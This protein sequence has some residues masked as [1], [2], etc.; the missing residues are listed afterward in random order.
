MTYCWT[1]AK[2]RLHI[3]ERPWP[4]H[5]NW[6]YC[7]VSVPHG[8][9]S[10]EKLR[11]WCVWFRHC[12]HSMMSSSMSNQWM[13]GG[14]LVMGIM[15]HIL[16]IL[17]KINDSKVIGWGQYWF[18]YDFLSN[19]KRF[20]LILFWPSNPFECTLYE[21]EVFKC[22]WQGTTQYFWYFLKLNRHWQIIFEKI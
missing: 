13:K 14:V 16:I 18:W 3:L 11:F 20:K 1:A 15:T 2:F 22:C 19:L 9:M 10:R 4:A 5:Y 17:M 6:F 7:E 8:L 12:I 21:D